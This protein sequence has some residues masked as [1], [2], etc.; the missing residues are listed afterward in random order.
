[1][2][3]EYFDLER[4]IVHLAIDKSVMMDCRHKWLPRYEKRYRRNLFLFR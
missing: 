3:R 1:M 2:M 4:Q